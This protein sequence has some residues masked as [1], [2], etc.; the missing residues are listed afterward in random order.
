MLYVDGWRGEK[1]EDGGFR[2]GEAEGCAALRAVNLISG[3]VNRVALL[4]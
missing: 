2:S 1:A 4:P 3:V